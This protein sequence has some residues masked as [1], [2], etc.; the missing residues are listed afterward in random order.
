M[1]N[2]LTT[3]KGR[4]LELVKNQGF[5]VSKFFSEIGDNYENFKGSR[6]TTSPNVDILVKIRTKIPNA[7]IDWIL[8]GN[9][10]MLNESIKDDPKKNDII[11]KFY[12][13]FETRE[14]EHKTILEQNSEIIKQNS[15]IIKQNS[16][17]M[18]QNGE[19]IKIVAKITE[20]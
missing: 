7:N 9:G 16:E 4:I 15:E 3:I 20:K 11:D 14:E 2:N 17:V 5:Q 6:L 1:G 18:R 12:I 8:T 10:D 13:L 19:L